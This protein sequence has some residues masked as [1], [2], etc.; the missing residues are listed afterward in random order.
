MDYVFEK[1]ADEERYQVRLGGEFVIYTHT[2]SPEKLDEILLE[3]GYMSRE[4]YYN[5]SLALNLS[6]VK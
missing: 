2:P 4:D 1:M 3:S 6:K 5:E